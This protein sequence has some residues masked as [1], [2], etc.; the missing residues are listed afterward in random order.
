M[1]VSGHVTVGRVRH[2]RE[3]DPADKAL[4]LKPLEEASE[5]LEA[6]KAW[7]GAQGGPPSAERRCRRALLDEIADGVQ[8]L[9]NLAHAAGEDDLGEAMGRCEGRNRRKWRY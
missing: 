1:R 2:F 6:W 3:C 4:A 7:R 9:C 8:A 5:V